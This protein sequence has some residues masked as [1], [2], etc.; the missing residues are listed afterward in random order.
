M[1]HL[2]HIYIRIKTSHITKGKEMAL[3][4]TMNLGA[5][6]PPPLADTGHLVPVTGALVLVA[7]SP[8]WNAMTFFTA[9]PAVLEAVVPDARL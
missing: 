7:V 1:S 8:R 3:V 5:L 6:R 2:L 4:S 9:Q